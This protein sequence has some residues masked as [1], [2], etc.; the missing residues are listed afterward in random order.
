M[1]ISSI[2]LLASVFSSSVPALQIART[3]PT[4][5]SLQTLLW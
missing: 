1:S 4:K 5:S 3:Q 2:D